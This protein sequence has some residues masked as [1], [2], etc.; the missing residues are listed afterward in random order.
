M[1]TSFILRRQISIVG[2][3]DANGKCTEENDSEFAS[4]NISTN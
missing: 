1:S 2:T 3:P 4:S